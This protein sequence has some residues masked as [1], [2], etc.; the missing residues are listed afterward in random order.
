VRSKKRPFYGGVLCGVRACA[1][2]GNGL[3]IKACGGCAHDTIRVAGETFENEFAETAAERSAR[4]Q[5]AEHVK[6]FATLAI[7][8]KIALRV[9]Q[10]AR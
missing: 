10:T 7:H 1:L 3:E 9:A 4:S 2:S 5:A 8:S 6:G